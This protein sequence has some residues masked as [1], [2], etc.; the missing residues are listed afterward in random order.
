MIPFHVVAI[1][2]ISVILLIVIGLWLCFKFGILDSRLDRTA[3][4]V[5]SILQSIIDGHVDCFELDD[6][7]CIP[8]IDA[9]LD[10]IRVDWV[11][12]ENEFPDWNCAGPFPAEGRMQLEDLV[13]RANSIL[14][15][16]PETPARSEKLNGK[17]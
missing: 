7:E 16:I 9:R 5:A 1:F 3:N 13:R 11:I 17:T 8:I 4:E 12:L 10:H 2:V 14:K 6:F 15:D